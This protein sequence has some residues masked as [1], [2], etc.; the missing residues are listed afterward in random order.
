LKVLPMKLPNALLFDMD[1]T[2]T[3]PYFD[4]P[5]IRAEIGVVEGG[6]LEFIEQLPPDQRAAAEAI[7]HGHEAR[8]A[9]ESTLNPGCD[10][11]MTWVERQQLPT[12]LITRNTR[13]SVA[14]VMDR[15]RLK[16]DC[17]V[18]R[19]DGRFKP[20]PAPLL[21]A[22]EKLNV[23]PADA[24]MIGDASYDCT[25]GAAAGVPTVWVSHGKARDFDAAPW[26]TVQDLPELLGLLR[27]CEPRV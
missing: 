6:L 16:F 3:A 13:K 19:E 18:T 17:L 8:A 9:M 23:R 21:L 4:Y 20:D 24:W 22:C 26:K 12:A 15:H 5:A 10:E 1:G 2:L 27:S 7:L 14:C 25:A 11:L